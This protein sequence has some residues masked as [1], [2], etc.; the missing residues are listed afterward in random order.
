MW[1]YYTLCSFVRGVFFH[2][3]NASGKFF[4]VIGGIV[5]CSCWVAPHCLDICLFTHLPVKG[6]QGYSQQMSGVC[7]AFD[8]AWWV[9]SFQ[10]LQTKWQKKIVVCSLLSQGPWPNIKLL[11]PKQQNYWLLDPEQSL[12]TRSQL[13]L[14]PM[15]IFE[16]HHFM[17]YSLEVKLTPSLRLLSCQAGWSSAL[18]LWPRTADCAGIWLSP[19]LGTQ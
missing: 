7:G 6:H 11:N 2:L 19:V 3:A 5:L 16:S 8:V 12:Q 1:Q 14:R 10:T 13:I 18:W 15:K 4:H 17:A 9:W